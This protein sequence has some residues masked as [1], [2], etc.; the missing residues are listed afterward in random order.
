M[1]LPIVNAEKPLSAQTACSEMTKALMISMVVPPLLS[2]SS[3]RCTP[4]LRPAFFQ[5]SRSMGRTARM[6]A[7][8]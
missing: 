1:A 4:K 3:V 2:Y 7:G 6:A 5:P 8:P